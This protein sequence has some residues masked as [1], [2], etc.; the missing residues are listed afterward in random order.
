MYTKIIGLS[1]K[2]R[3][4][5]LGKIRLGVKA[6]SQ[7]TGNDYPTETPYFVCPPEVEKIYGKQPTELD[8]LLPLE[9]TAI[10]I[11]QAYEYYGSSK[12]LKCIGDGE[13][14]LRMKDDTHD[15]IEREC[16]CEL[17]EQK[18]CSKR[19]HLRV[20]LPRVNIGGIYQI[21][22]S[23]FNSIIDINS[24][25]DYIRALVGRVALVPLKLRRVK[26]ETHH[27][28]KKQFHYTLK[29]ELEADLNF[30]NTLRENTSQI[31][32]NTKQ[33]SLPAPLAENPTMDEGATVVDEAEAIELEKQR[34]EGIKQKPEI[35]APKTKTDI[36]QPQDETSQFKKVKTGIEKITK[37]G[38]VYNIYGDGEV[39]KTIF[40]K[41]ANVAKSAKE[42]GLKVEIDIRKIDNEIAKIDIIEP[43]VNFETGEFGESHE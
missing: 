2:R 3:L 33:C 18:K 43:D 7:K 36:V 22:T 34:N 23:S 9:D 24:S 20:I 14:A 42:A 25:I 5:R 12:G 1:E 29:L 13:T 40:E 41:I 17:L 32:M 37:K 30:I 21:D 28:G 11:P 39:Y 16:P 27:E 4:P 8:V 15:M 19:M 10:T 38:T 6:K 31:L 26:T 35:S